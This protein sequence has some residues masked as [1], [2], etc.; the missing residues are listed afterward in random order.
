MGDEFHKLESLLNTAKEYLNTRIKQAKLGVVEKVSNLLST[1][2]ARLMVILVFLFAL[3]LASMAGA[4]AI[5]ESLGH[6]WLGFL[7][8]AGAWMILG[9]LI[10]VTRN[11]FVRIPIMNDIIRSLFN[12][13]QEAGEEDE[14]D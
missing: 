12:K 10:W 13:E 6:E 7:I 3:L 9:I 14:K 5:G 8:M 11:R 4:M 2:I 1:L